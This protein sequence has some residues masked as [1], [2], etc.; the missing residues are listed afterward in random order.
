MA[1]KVLS[2]GIKYSQEDV[3]K[4]NAIFQDMLIVSYT[5]PVAALANGTEALLK[6]IAEKKEKK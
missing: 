5:G 3:E 2:E 1:E 4:L 6:A